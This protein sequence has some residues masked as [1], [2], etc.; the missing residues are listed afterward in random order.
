[1]D[2]KE[3][4]YLIRCFSCHTANRVPVSSEGKAGKCGNCH[5]L[6]QQLHT[7]PVTLSD[8]T[9]D[10]F[11]KKFQGTLLVEFWAPW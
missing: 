4:T 3:A 2:T 11:A 8:N 6:L 7:K 9:F 5:A 10:V 1:M